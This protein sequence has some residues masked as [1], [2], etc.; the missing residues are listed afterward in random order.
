VEREDLSVGAC[1]A[2][3]AVEFV[4]ALRV[5]LLEMT[6]RLAWVE[7][8]DVTR[9]NARACAMRRERAALRRDIQEAQFLIDRLQHRYLGGNEESNNMN[10]RLG[11]AIG[12]NGGGFL[13]QNGLIRQSK[14]TAG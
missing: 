5:Q 8:Q 9:S 12:P 14:R 7:Q 6:S 2:A 1:Q 3:Q 13:P 4:R 11:H 10:V